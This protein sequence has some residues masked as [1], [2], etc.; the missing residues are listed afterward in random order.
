MLGTSN[1]NFYEIEGNIPSEI[2]HNFILKSNLW[3]H[4]R[5]PNAHLLVIETD[6]QISLFLGLVLHAVVMQPPRYV[7]I[8]SLRLHL[9]SLASLT[10]EMVLQSVPTLCLLHSSL[11]LKSTKINNYYEYCKH[12]LE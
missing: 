4:L 6:P 12:V 8:S 10:L 9:S 1:H 11:F 2:H 7:G 5:P 3:Q